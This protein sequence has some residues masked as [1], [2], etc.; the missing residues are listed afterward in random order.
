MFA[1]DAVYHKDCLTSLYNRRRSTER[2]NT[3]DSILENIALAEVISHIESQRNTGDTVSLF[4]LSDLARIYKYTVRLRA[5]G[6]TYVPE[7]TNS[8]RLKDQLLSHMPQMKA[9]HQGRDLLLGFDDDI[10]DAL[11]IASQNNH[12]EKK[13]TGTSS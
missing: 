7:R 11:K 9:Y 10:G 5:L 3:S 2:I 1:R 13:I 4:K 8:T 6:V 12:N